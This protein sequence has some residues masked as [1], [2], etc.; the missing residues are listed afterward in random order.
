MRSL[1]TGIFLA[2]SLY[3]LLTYQ[4]GEV[5]T[6]PEI[7]NNHGTRRKPNE[8]FTRQLRYPK[9]KSELFSDFLGKYLRK[10]SSAQ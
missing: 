2:M 1:L 3:I 9:P 4:F 7:M 5:L 6:M 10:F 8:K